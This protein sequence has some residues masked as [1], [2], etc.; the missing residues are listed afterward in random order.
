VQQ[1]IIIS[2]RPQRGPKKGQLDMMRT[3]IGESGFKYVLLLPFSCSL[4][5]HQ[6]P[7]PL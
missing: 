3:R 6:N 7:Q 4:F 2:K 1:C 5:Y